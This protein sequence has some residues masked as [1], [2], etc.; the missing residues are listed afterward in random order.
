MARVL[1]EAFATDPAFEY[2]LPPRISRRDKRLERFFRDEVARSRR[3]GGAWTTE[4]AAGAAI[5]YPPGRWKPSTWE[6]LKATPSA[7]RIF[8]RQL[9]L[10]MRALNVLQKHHPTVAHWYLYYLGTTPQR[11]STGIGSMLMRPVLQTCDEQGIPAYLEATS[12][13]NRDLY[14]RHG[15]AP[16][17][18]LELPR[19][20]PTVHPMWREPQ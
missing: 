12:E 9:P 2:M 20:G 14:L 4:D 16:T 18:V 11:Q 5:W 10:G 3:L 19:G 17:E 8:G 1:A 7:V 15:F 13:R 6:M